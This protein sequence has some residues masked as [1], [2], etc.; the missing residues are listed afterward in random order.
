MKKHAGFTL[1]EVAAVL[2]ILALLAAMAIPRMVD[3]SS[4]ALTA[5]KNGSETAVR[6]AQAMAISDLK[7]PPQLAELVNYVGG[8]QATVDS[9]N[10]GIRV[11]INKVA[12]VVPTYTDTTCGAPTAAA[13]DVV[14][15]V[16]KIH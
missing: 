1:I 8:Q 4:D 14:N 5:A 12:Y 13:N 3:G 11:T 10:A 16:G 9:S 2:A 15:C 6:A 7:R